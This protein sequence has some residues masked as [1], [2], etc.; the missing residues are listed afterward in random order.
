MQT[1][2]RWIWYAQK[3]QGSECIEVWLCLVLFL[4][5]I[6]Y[7]GNVFKWLYLNL[8]LL[9]V[10]PLNLLLVQIFCCPHC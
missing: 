9:A 5:H 10:D 3:N 6:T 4:I 2:S 7:Y 1:I 8:F